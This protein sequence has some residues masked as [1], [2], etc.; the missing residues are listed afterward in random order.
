MVV[1][2]T[3]AVAA[4][5]VTGAV[6]VV[7]EIAVAV[8]ATT[9]TKSV[10][11]CETKEG[12]LRLRRPLSFLIR[13]MLTKSTLRPLETEVSMFKKT[14]LDSGV[15]VVTERIPSVRSLAV[16]IWV[17]VGSRDE[18][19]EEMGISHFIEHAVFRGT[20]RRRTH[21]IAQFMESV[22]GY[23]NAFTSKEQ[24]CYLAR[25][26]DE[27]LPRALDVLSDLVLEPTFPAKEIEREKDVVLE[28]IRMYADNPEDVVFDVYEEQMY[29]NHP[30]GRP[31]IGVPETVQS[32][33][34]GQ[35][36]QYI[37]QH[38]TPDR[39]VVAAA[40]NLEHEHVL[41]LIQAAFAKS[42]RMPNPHRRSPVESY[43][44]S[45]IQQ[46]KSI[47]QAHVVMG[48]PSYDLH[49]P[50]RT[51]LSVLNTILGGGMSSRLN[52]NV[53]EKYGYC[54][55]IYSFVNFQQD[56][57]DFGIYM[58]TDPSKVERAKTVVLRE[59]EKLTEKPVSKRMLNMAKNQVK[60]ALMMGLESLNNR[61][62]RI[63]KQEIYYNRYFSL[64]EVTRFIDEV[65]EAKVQEVAQELFV[66]ERFSH[67]V[68]SP[69]PGV[70][71]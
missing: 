11:T 70:E 42:G 69:K 1:V 5:V 48:T 23:L 13:C 61:M 64:D 43:T 8:V 45:A 50:N 27:H 57:G 2:V 6:V 19:D 54:Y 15:R 26:L 62:N 59:L 67:T 36:S 34:P 24:T 17:E 39:I 68:I 37:D 49:H 52:Q 18:R 35:L 40:G 32:F 66:P 31:I 4:V 71:A 46:A 7:V 10:H 22:G 53:R 20:K 41:D 33:T 65:D 3:G 12:A 55:N 29:A 16:G 25:C 56:S 47:Q 21:N 9:K 30:L 14:I 60:G 38:Y 44:P 63:A 58:G 51:A 28:E